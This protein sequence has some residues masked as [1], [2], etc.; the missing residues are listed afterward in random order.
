MLKYL[1]VSLSLAC[2]FVCY[3]RE[4]NAKGEPMFVVSKISKSGGEKLDHLSS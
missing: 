3:R 2:K 1:K 4:H